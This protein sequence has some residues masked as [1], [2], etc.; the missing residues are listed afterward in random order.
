MGDVIELGLTAHQLTPERV[1]E[2]AKAAK[3]TDIVVAGNT[4]DGN[5]FFCMSKVEACE[6]NW[7]LDCAKKMLMDSAIIDVVDD[8]G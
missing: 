2:I 8:N 5:V 7:L 6:A 4:P 1:L 3:L